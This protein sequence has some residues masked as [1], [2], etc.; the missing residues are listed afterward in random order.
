MRSIPLAICWET[1]SRGRRIL[2]LGALGANLIP[3]FLFSAI[4]QHGA[5]DT[6]DPGQIMMHIVLMHLNLFLFGTAVLFAQ[7]E[8]SRLYVAPVTTESLVLCQLLPSMFLVSAECLLSTWALNAM[9]ALNWPVWGPAI[10]V[11]VSWAAVQATIWQT[12]KS[13]WVVVALTTVTVALGVWLRS[14]HGSLFSVPTHLWHQLTALEI[15][16]MVSIAV[17]SFFVAVSGVARNRCG[18]TLPPSGFMALFERL[19]DPLPAVGRSFTGSQNAYEWAVWR[20]KGWAMPACVVFGTIVAL[21][22]WL[23]VRPTPQDLLKGGVAGGG[24]LSVVGVFGGLI[25][26]NCG[27][28]D[29]QFAMGSFDASKPISTMALARAILINLGKSV[30]FAWLLWIGPFVSILLAVRISGSPIE[31]KLPPALGWW[32]FPLTILGPWT[33]AGVIGTLVAFGRHDFFTRVFSGTI[34]FFFLTVGLSQHFL[35][36]ETQAQAVQLALTIASAL[37][38]IGAIVAFRTACRQ[39]LVTR[40]M[41]WMSALAWVGSAAMIITTSKVYPVLSPVM[42]VLAMGVLALAILPVATIPLALQS[43][44]IR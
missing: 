9:F 24:L 28:E 39:Q 8:P 15:L 20:T 32:F 4:L 12:E 13:G 35:S 19:F 7:P 27:T 21:S 1:W 26:C 5:I 18:E 3:V 42:I 25:V 44:R 37:A 38:V 22:L 43:N 10:F 41:T 33:V 34:F 11:A 16:T 31:L 29:R 17:V 14:R 6:Q 23:F 40:E 30:V 36:K 2:I